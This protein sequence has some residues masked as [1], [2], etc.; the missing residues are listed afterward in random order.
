M[1]G[2]RIPP[3]P[4]STV[5]PETCRRQY[6]CAFR[7]Q[8]PERSRPPLGTLHDTRQALRGDCRLCFLM[9]RPAWRDIFGANAIRL[10]APAIRGAPRRSGI[11]PIRRSEPSCPR[12]CLPA[13]KAD[14][15]GAWRGQRC[16]FC[17]IFRRW[18]VRPGR[19]EVSTQP[20]LQLRSDDVRDFSPPATEPRV[21][22]KDH[23]GCSSHSDD[24]LCR[25]STPHVAM[26]SAHAVAHCSVADC[27]STL[28]CASR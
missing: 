11:P 8:A 12:S 22:V 24:R 2:H 18:P 16:S 17:R 21:Q 3:V 1:Y 10:I 15:A 26:D 19:L 7:Q 13:G 6:R 28:P 5:G 27:T 20:V 23:F 14:H 9:K 4:V 25:H